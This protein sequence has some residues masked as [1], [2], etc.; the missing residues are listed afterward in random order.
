[1]D[2]GAPNATEGQLLAAT[3]VQLRSR[4]EALEPL[5]DIHGEVQELID[6]LS[7][8]HA[9][10]PPPKPALPIHARA[11][12]DLARVEKELRGLSEKLVPLVREHEQITQVLAAFRAA[13][14]LEVDPSARRRPRAARAPSSTLPARQDELRNLLDQARSRAELAQS[15]SLSPS[16]ITELLEPLVRSGEVRESRDPEQPTRKLYALHSGDAWATP[17]GGDHPPDPGY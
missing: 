4:R 8:S 15:M 3:E 13:S 2:E 17:G 14:R 12:K 9:A 7:A 10:D 5:L 6:L 16:R 1:M 11:V